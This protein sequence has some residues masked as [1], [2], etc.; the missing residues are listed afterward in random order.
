MKTI[1]SWIIPFLLLSRVL[2]A[3]PPVIVYH[4][5]Q[6][7]NGVS[8]N[9]PATT[10]IVIQKIKVDNT[11]DNT[12][13]YPH[14]YDATFENIGTAPDSDMVT[15]KLWFDTDGTWDGNETLLA[16]HPFVSGV[17]SYSP[18]NDTALEDCHIP[19]GSS[20][21]IYLTVD[22]STN[23]TDK[24]TIK[25][26][27]NI[28]KLPFQLTD[29]SW[30]DLL[31]TLSSPGTTNAIEV[32]A[33]QL[34]ISNLPV[35]TIRGNTFENDITVKAVDSYGNVDKDFT[36]TVYFTST[37]PDAVFTYASPGS[38]YTFTPADEGEKTFDKGGFVL[39][40][41]GSHNITV[42]DASTGL[43]NA[44]SDYF[45]VQ[46]GLYHFDLTAV[47]AADFPLTVPAGA[48]W[49]A[50]G[51]GLTGIKAQIFDNADMVYEDYNGT[52]YSASTEAHSD[53]RYPVSH[54]YVP[55]TDAGTYV[56]DVSNLRLCRAGNQELYFK[57]TQ[58][59]YIGALTV[60]VVPSTY[61]VLEL[62]APS[63]VNAQTEFDVTLRASDAYGNPVTTANRKV[64]LTSDNPD[65]SA[66]STV[67]F[68][69][70]EATAKV[71]MGGLGTYTL[72]VTDTQDESIRA[73]ANITVK[74]KMDKD[75]SL[76][77]TNNYIVPDTAKRSVNIFVNKTSQG[78][79]KVTINVFDTRG[80]VVKR[81]SPQP[82]QK[83][84]NRLEPW[85]LTGENGTSVASGVYII[86][87]HGSGVPT[88][89]RMAV[90]VR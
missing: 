84:V 35:N 39:N 36:G 71:T 50:L 62:T 68:D 2:F 22:L 90:I 80:R 56:F 4:G 8:D 83:G 32:D 78:K 48:Y 7:V 28:Q 76:G 63:S 41:T 16:A 89:R 9:G 77:L 42:H 79:T 29:W 27:V 18:P 73:S 3:G 87:I 69:E 12:A 47:G 52:V 21:Y 5:D 40:T 88:S 31:Q 23:V 6:T 67:R 61:A 46:T 43:N 66:P 54:T 60:T 44:V 49:N 10:G 25:S 72:T 53:N 14:L 64:S 51:D 85:D 15:T 17:V 13:T 34:S 58:F 1:S 70:G 37:D 38:G 11:G 33:T 59:N 86:S 75:M 81:F 57:D 55:G 30:S 82:C 26:R 19:G 65:F 20:V 45:T 74:M 24:A